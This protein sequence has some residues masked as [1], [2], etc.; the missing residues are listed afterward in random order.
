LVRR[1]GPGARWVTRF[2]AA[3]ADPTR[4]R[5]PVAGY[6][7][8]ERKVIAFHRWEKGGPGDDVVV[9]TNFF[10]EAQD[11]CAMGFPA[12]RLWKLRFNSDR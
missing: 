2:C 10:H 7:H 8:D 12:A 3:Q 5:R 4:C 1:D 6:L 11:G 9:V